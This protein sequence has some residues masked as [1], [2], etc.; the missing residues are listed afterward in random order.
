[1]Q[2]VT[3]QVSA[4]KISTDWT[5]DL[6][7]NT[8]T[9]GASYSLMIIL[10]NSHH[11]SLAFPRFCTTSAQ[12][13]SAAEITCPKYLKEVTISRGSSYA[14]KALEVISL[15]SSSVSCRL[16]RPAPFLHYTVRR[17][18]PFRSRHDTIMLHRGHRGWGRFPSSGITTVSRTCRC[19]KFTR[20]AVHV[21]TRTLHPSTVKGLGPAFSGNI[22]LNA[23]VLSPPLPFS[24]VC[25]SPS[26]RHSVLDLALSSQGPP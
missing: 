26:S 16:F 9:R 24:S 13:L 8:D 14:L 15:S 20:M 1:M 25:P 2:G 23:M 12:S 7:K 4:P 19:H 18:I 21:T 3:T 17:C 5:T 22:I 10:G 11:A 6:N